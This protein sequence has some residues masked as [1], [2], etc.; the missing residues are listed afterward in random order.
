MSVQ[1]RSDPQPTSAGNI[2]NAAANLAG[3]Q[4]S[5]DQILQWTMEGKVF[6]AAIPVETA[7]Q[8]VPATLADITPEAALTADNDGNKFVIPISTTVS[9]D[10]A[11]G[12]AVHQA[13]LV[14]VRPRTALATVNTITGTGMT[15]TNNRSD[16]FGT[17]TARAIYGGTSAAVAATEFV[18]LVTWGTYTGH[19]E[20]TNAFFGS[21]TKTYNHLREGAP[22]ILH[23]GASLFVYAWEGNG[24][25]LAR[26]VFTWV[27][28]DTSTYKP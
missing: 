22:T 19:G 28:L 25:A 3:E 24:A 9:W 17:E 20:S 15:I 4:I 14:H 2:I 5:A 11:N 12:S 16:L 13:K 10:K 7:S 1:A 18:E 8:A 27:E 6:T 26:Y 23:S 21:L